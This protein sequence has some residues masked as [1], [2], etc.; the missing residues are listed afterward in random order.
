MKD[1]KKILEEETLKRIA[2]ENRLQSLKEDF[3]FKEEVCNFS[4]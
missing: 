4:Y 3:K 1:A 2:A